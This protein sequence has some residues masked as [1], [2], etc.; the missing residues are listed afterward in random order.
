M[1]NSARQPSA[2]CDTETSHTASHPS[3]S[4]AS[5]DHATSRLTPAGLTANSNA[6]RRSWN[7]STKTRIQ[8]DG[9]FESRRVR[10]PMMRDG[11]GSCANTATYMFAAS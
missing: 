4:L 6:L 10:S 8:S 2:A 9:E 11:S 5:F 7:E 1:R 3:S